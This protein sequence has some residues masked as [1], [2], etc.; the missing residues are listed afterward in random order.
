MGDKI[1][2]LFSHANGSPQI[3]VWSRT[4]VF[5]YD[6][7]FPV[8]LQVMQQNQSLID[9]Q[10]QTIAELQEINRKLSEKL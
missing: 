3:G 7:L 8:M 1:N 4:D 10:K 5:L 2:N 9:L 6:K